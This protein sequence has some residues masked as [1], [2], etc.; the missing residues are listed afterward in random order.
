MND[1]PSFGEHKLLGS[2]GSNPSLTV[3]LFHV[4]TR[5]ERSKSVRT[6]HRVLPLVRAGAWRIA[7][8]WRSS[9]IDSRFGLI[10]GDCPDPSFT[11]NSG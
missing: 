8:V 11:I 10:A 2:E 5:V 1:I 7:D 6:I 4:H 9:G 3:S